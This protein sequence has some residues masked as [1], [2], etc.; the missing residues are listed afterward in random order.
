MGSRGFFLRQQIPEKLKRHKFEELLP[1]QDRLPGTSSEFTEREVSH[2]AG[3]RW[4]DWL[5]LP[6]I[7]REEIIAHELHKNM[8]NAY[9]SEMSRKNTGKKK[10][11]G[12]DPMESI[13][14]QFTSDRMKK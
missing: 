1:E 5:L 12:V 3:Y 13:M 10:G 11:G 9:Y 2:A 6:T 4:T 14:A 7:V 8:R